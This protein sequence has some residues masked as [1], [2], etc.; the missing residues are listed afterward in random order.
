VH[1][2]DALIFALAAGT[3]PAAVLTIKDRKLV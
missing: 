2:E 3:D 1:F